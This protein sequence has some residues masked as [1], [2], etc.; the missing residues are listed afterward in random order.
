MTYVHVLSVERQRISQC[1]Y[2]TW[3]LVWPCDG[4]FKN[5]LIQKFLVVKKFCNFQAAQTFNTN[6]SAYILHN[7]MQVKLCIVQKFLNNKMLLAIILH[8]TWNI[9]QIAVIMTNMN[10]LP[11]FVLRRL[12]IYPPSIQCFTPGVASFSH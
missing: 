4:N 6:F 1:M 8:V 10:F 3:H 2:A 12:P 9:S 7:W 11:Y 5:T